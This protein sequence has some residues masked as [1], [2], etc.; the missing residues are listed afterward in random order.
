M[1]IPDPVL[2]AHAVGKLRDRANAEG[3]A[4]LCTLAPREHRRRVVEATVALQVMYDY[5]DA[6]TEQ[7][8]DDPRRN[9]L[10]LFRAFAAA[11]TPGGGVVDYYRFNPQDDDGGYLD[12]LVATIQQSIVGLPAL[13]AVLP[14]MR[15]ATER[16]TEGQVRS[17]AVAS[18]GVAQLEEWALEHADA[19]DMAWWEWAGGAAASVLAV[20]ALLSAAADSRTSCVQAAR[21][22]HAC[23]MH[24]AL[25]TMLDS[26][27]DNEGD[28]AS[29]AHRYI[30]YYPSAESAASRIAA[31][32]RAAVSAA[33][34]LP[35]AAHHAMTVAGIA[36][37][38]LSALDMRSGMA[39][40]IGARVTREL[41]PVIRPALASLRLWRRLQRDQ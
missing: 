16:F 4:T 7:P 14:T 31:I 11:L 36:A 19:I 30:A 8:V 39:Q 6:V 24:S 26:L 29:G 2:R 23:L 17:H 35:H 27:V 22:D 13:D 3:V 15:E 9:G 32:A 38:H 10:Q 18:A 25:A 20:H 33:R 41:K 21:I 34:E 1:A 37:F 28:A 40:A 12:A 5:L